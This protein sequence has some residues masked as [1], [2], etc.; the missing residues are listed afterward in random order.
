VTVAGTRPEIIKL[1]QIIPLLNKHFRH[2]F[3][4]T[5]QHFPSN[6]KEIFFENLDIQPDYDFK[7]NTSD[8]DFIKNA[9]GSDINKNQPSIHQRVW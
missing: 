8:I 1:A 2:K 4:Y 9:M 3:V 5:G 6:M 7:C